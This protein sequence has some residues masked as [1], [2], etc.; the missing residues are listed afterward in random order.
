MNKRYCVR[1]I[2]SS[3]DCQASLT[4]AIKT[5][6]G[7]EEV[8]IN[9]ATGEITYGPATCD[10]NEGKLRAAVKKAGF[11]LDEIND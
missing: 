2:N 11:E 6:T 7:A 1:D 8:H 5:A 9:M 4:T 10:M 3:P